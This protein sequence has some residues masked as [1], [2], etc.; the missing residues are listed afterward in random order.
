MLYLTVY[1]VRTPTAVEATATPY[2]IMQ[3]VYAGDAV[4]TYRHTG[5]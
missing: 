5:S 3:G 2:S 4:H 1:V